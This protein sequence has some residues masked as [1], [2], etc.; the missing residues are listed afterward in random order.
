MMNIQKM[1]QQAQ[2]MQ[3]KLAELQEKFKDLIVEGESG[4]GAVK[5]SMACDGRVKT[6]EVDE[7]VEEDK[8]TRNDL[9][10]AAINNA[11]EAKEARIQDETKK[12]M[13][14][15]GLPA[16]TPLPF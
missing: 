6:L 2:V 8:E 14:A 15:L 3:Q 11:T 16:D 5:V 9:I 7:A 10:I 13:E 12:E 4:S 1:M